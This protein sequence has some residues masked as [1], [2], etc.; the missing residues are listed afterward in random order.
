MRLEYFMKRTNLILLLFFLLTSLLWANE[1]AEP[2]KFKADRMEYIYKKGK[3]QVICRG[4]ARVERSD[5]SLKARLIYIYG[6]N[7][8]FVKAYNDVKM[9]NKIDEVV[10]YGDYAE[11]DNIAGYG[12]VFKSPRLVYTNEKLEMESAIMETFINENRSIAFG[13]VKITQ[14][15]YVAY[16]EKA[17]Y[18]H[19]KDTIELTGDPVIYYE[20]NLFRAEKIIIYIKKKLVK[21]YGNVRARIS[22]KD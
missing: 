3:E 19:K 13:D 18:W 20:E 16:C 9:I 5:F 21:L 14:T 10:I 17:I 8:D 6:E 11:Y 15:N 7:R 1:T 4:R 2:I 12:K 22:S